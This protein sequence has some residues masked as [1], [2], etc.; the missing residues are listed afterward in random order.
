MKTIVIPSD[1]SAESIQLA[2]AIVRNSEEEVRLIFTHLFHVP[3]DIQ[4]LLFSTYRKKEYD[5]VSEVFRQEC[6]LLKELYSEKFKGYHIEFFYGNKLAAF[7]NFLE[8]NDA[9]CIAYSQSYGVPKLSKSSIDA[10]P[11]IKKS[12][13]PLIDFDLV[14]ELEENERTV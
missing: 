14:E 4:D 8:A 5:Y 1:F 6:D 12:G 9:S 10:L 2:K 13:L 11:V 3:D 7:K